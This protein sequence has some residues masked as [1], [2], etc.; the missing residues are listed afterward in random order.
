MSQ[1]PFPLAIRRR[2][3]GDSELVMV[4]GD[5]LAVH[6]QGVVC[7]SSTSLTLHSAVAARIVIRAI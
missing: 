5:L 1:G 6:A 3:V 2:A 4:A 7:Y